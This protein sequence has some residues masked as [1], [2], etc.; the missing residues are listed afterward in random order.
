MSKNYWQGKQIR[1]RA[2][3]DADLERY[4]AERAQPDSIRQ[5][6]E[7]ELLFPASEK[8]VRKS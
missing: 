1:L 8:E 6:Y 4:I 7:D 5:W 3:E 2:L